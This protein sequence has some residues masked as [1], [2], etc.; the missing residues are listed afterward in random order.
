MRFKSKGFTVR[1]I[2]LNDYNK[3]DGTYTTV[4]TYS[5]NVSN[6]TTTISKISRQ[7]NE[8]DPEV[9]GIHN[10]HQYVI[11]L[12]NYKNGM[13]DKNTTEIVYN[14][15]AYQIF[16]QD[17]NDREKRLILMAKPKQS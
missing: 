15:N 7:I 5:G 6:D 16:Y 11:E 9:I 2:N 17:Y 4:G 10:E 1:T 14:G 8:F 13:L 3:P 12:V